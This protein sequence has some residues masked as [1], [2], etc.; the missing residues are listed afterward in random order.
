MKYSDARTC[1]SLKRDLLGLQPR[2]LGAVAFMMAAC[3]TYE[4][5]YPYDWFQLSSSYVYI[6]IDR[7]IYLRLAQ[8]RS[9]LSGV[10]RL[11]V[12]QVL[13]LKLRKYLGDWEFEKFKV[14]A[15][16]VLASQGLRDVVDGWSDLDLRCQLVLK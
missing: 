2:L 12:Y 3:L 11:C 8:T 1:P 5:F 7:Y 4:A 6:Y 15:L 16:R 14:N 13:S 10:D 9:R